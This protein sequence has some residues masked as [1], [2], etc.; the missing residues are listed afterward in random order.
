LDVCEI[1]EFLV[2]IGVSR[3]TIC[4]KDVVRLEKRL[5]VWNIDNSLE[6]LEEFLSNK[7]Y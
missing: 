3:I 5:Q 1:V 2:D 6:S 4:D 7:I